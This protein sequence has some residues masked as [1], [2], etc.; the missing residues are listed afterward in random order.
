MV[1][2]KNSRFKK[3]KNSYRRLVSI[4]EV[5]KEIISD[6]S[7]PI[8]SVNRFINLALHTT[9]DG[10]QSRQFLLESKEGIRKTSVLLTR[11]NKYAKKI[12]QEI[13]EISEKGSEGKRRKI[14]DKRQRIN[15]K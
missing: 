3:K 1:N 6:L 8:D 12:E 13:L 5:T 10:S 4:G 15:S 7:S 9:S 11:L 2:S 14:N